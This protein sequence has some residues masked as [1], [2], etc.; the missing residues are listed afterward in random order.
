MVCIVPG[1][2]TKIIHLYLNNKN[3]DVGGPDKIRPLWRHYFQNT[4]ALIFVV[5]S[6]DRYRV[7]E[8]A[9]EMQKVL[10][11]DEVRDAALLVFANKQVRFPPLG[12][13]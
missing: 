4:D 6:N 8:I 5:D 13:R 12:Y 3:R 1:L 9:E 7:P 11:E 10:R 2:C